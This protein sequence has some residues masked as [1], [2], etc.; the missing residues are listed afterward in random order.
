MGYN[1]TKPHI[2]APYTNHWY[3]FGRPVLYS[4]C[5]LQETPLRTSSDKRCSRVKTSATSTALLQGNKFE[6]PQKI[7]LCGRFSVPGC[8][9]LPASCRW[10]GNPLNAETSQLFLSGAQLLCHQFKTSTSDF[11]R[12]AL[13]C[14]SLYLQPLLG[15]GFL[16]GLQLHFCHLTP[17]LALLT[18]SLQT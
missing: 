8:K 11:D 9:C 12:E 3:C 16:Q 13:A 5:L 7:I 2:E 17:Q 15:C 6:T 14:D 1:K 10:V 4:L 18:I